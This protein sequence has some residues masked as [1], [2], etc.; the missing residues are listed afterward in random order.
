MESGNITIMITIPIS[1][2]IT[3]QETGVFTKS[4]HLIHPLNMS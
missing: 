2:H 1:N 3:N 4:N